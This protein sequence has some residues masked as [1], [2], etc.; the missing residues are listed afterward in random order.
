[1][2]HL[3]NKTPKRQAIWMQISILL[4]SIMVVVLFV[5]L[6]VVVV[7]K[8]LDHFGGLAWGYLVIIAVLVAVE[9]KMI[10]V[11]MS[12]VK[13]ARKKA[14]DILQTSGTEEETLKENEKEGPFV[15]K[16]NEKEENDVVDSNTHAP[17]LPTN[18]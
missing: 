9:G 1:M 17:L 7:I 10:W 15:E 5:T 18:Y 12:I 8:N 2:Y 13:H 11:K 14:A 3:N 16:D 4:Q 6:P